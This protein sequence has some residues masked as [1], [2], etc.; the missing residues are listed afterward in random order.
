M[1][2]AIIAAQLAPSQSIA[3][4]RLEYNRDIRPIL[5][6]NCF[7]CHGPDSASRKADLRLDQFDAAVDSGAIEPGDS[8]SS[9]F[10]ARILTDDP[11]ALMPPADS[12]K[13]LT[14]EQKQL[15]IAWID[16]GAEYQA[17]WSFIAPLRPEPPAV[18][19]REWIRNP[20]DSFILA[21]LEASGLSPEVE[22][23][24]ALLARRVALD[25]TGLPPSPEVLRTFLNDTSPDAYERLVDH[26]LESE[27]WGEHR[28]RYWLDYARYADTHGYHFDNF[29]EMWTY[30]DWLINAFNRNMPF[31]QFT[32]ESLAGD[33][34]PNATLDQQIASGFHRCNMTT[35]EG[36]IIDEEYRV[37]YARDRTETTAQVWMGLTAGCAVCHDHKFDPIT[38]RDFYSMSAFFTNTTQGVRDGNIKDTPPIIVVPLAED[39]MRYE[40]LLREAPAARQAVDTR[41]NQAS[42]DFQRWLSEASADQ[43]AARIPGEA[44]LIAP[45]NEGAGAKA[46]IIVDG[47][48][49]EIALA[50]TTGW[51]PGQVYPSAAEVTREGIA[52]L[53]DA[54]DFN[55]DQPYSIGAWIRL[56]ANDGYGAIASRMEAPP[57]YR[58]WDFWVQQRR[59]GM[60]IISKWNEDALKVVS[61]DQVPA[62]QWTH[63]L[64]TYDGSRKAAGVKVYF[65]GVEQPTNVEAN[66]LQ[67]SNRTDVPFKI[68]QRS[69]SEPLAGL[70]LQ[71]LRMYGRKL[72]SADVA[73]LAQGSRLAALAAKPAAELADAE[74]QEL[75]DWWLSA[76]DTQS[77]ELVNQAN[78]LQRELDDIKARGSIAHVMQERS[79]EAEAHILF[80]GAYDQRRDRVTPMTPGSLPAFPEDFPRN[81]LGL[82]QWLLLP[83]HPLTARVTVN[84]C[85]QEVFGQGLVRTSGDFGVT[86]ELPS[87][88]ELLDW[89]AV[90]FRESGW[91]VKQLYKLMVMSAAYR[92]S[93]R[94]T[95]VKLELD[96]QN[97]LLSRGPRFRMDAEMVRDSALASSGLLVNRIGGPSVKPYQPPG[98]W[99]AIAMNVSNTRSY[100][101]DQGEGLYRRSMYTFVKRMAPP[102]GMEV[103]NAPNREY[104]IVRRERTNTPLQALATLNDE[105][106]VEA[107]R[108]LA[109]EALREQDSFE[110][111]VDYITTRLIARPL[112]EQ[113]KQ[114]V[115]ESLEQLREYYAA[116]EADGKELLNVGYSEFDSELP[117][118]ESAAWTML[119]NQLMNLDENLC[120]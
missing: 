47:E 57:E 97:R 26:L 69:A 119:V 41:R 8:Q 59:V 19:N 108:H 95:G 73:S 9:E 45:L 10:V 40:Q 101:E 44:A 62:N 33:L 64:V 113:E 76:V 82:A 29:R 79:S 15:L 90:E 49:R 20:I 99:E 5:A 43:F 111:R 24:R 31:D 93:A 67:G 74:R 6:D 55:S 87:H 30:R 51:Q 11:D 13:S 109:Q 46:T 112:N 50:E 91:D 53:A 102:A 39:R 23:D 65:N 14:E 7:A 117:T 92:Q 38:M 34:L 85:W 21:R 118:A 68:G 48:P 75:F 71:D 60:H 116:H 98:V 106:Y 86:G 17:H 18:R 27:A 25:L 88:P 100:Q 83:D 96:P 80:R 72:E 56:P 36:G 4:E 35:N 28:A 52:T 2:A 32:V 84:R 114:V 37:L 104:C 94:A 22:A 54:G 105:Q 107:A 16:Q 70:Q 89:L 81:R 120:K 110:G 78:A 12:H 77:M 61:R 42:E 1:A 63:V 66:Q 58:G 103:F 115:R 3:Q